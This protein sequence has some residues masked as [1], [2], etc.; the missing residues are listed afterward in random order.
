[1]QE[2]FLSDFKQG[3]IKKS[4]IGVMEKIT[5]DENSK[6]HPYLIK[7]W[8]VNVSREKRKLEKYSKTFLIVMTEIYSNEER[9]NEVID[10][11]PEELTPHMR[12]ILGATRVEAI[13]NLNR[14]KEDS[15][16]ELFEKMVKIMNDSIPL[17]TK[18]GYAPQSEKQTLKYVPSFVKRFFDGSVAKS[19]N[20][21]AIA[22][23]NNRPKELLSIHNKTEKEIL[24]KS[25]TKD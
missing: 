22:A 8:E 15:P 19:Y 1:L 18:P 3:Q 14:M 23:F 16:I 24:L 17:A 10:S 13:A 25:I 2:E 20:S 21:N 4:G 7:I 5:D 11:I 6:Y 9:W 12:E